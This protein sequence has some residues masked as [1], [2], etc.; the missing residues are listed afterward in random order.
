METES[1]IEGQGTFWEVDNIAFRGI[2]KNFIG[3]KIKAEFL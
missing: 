3:E 1:E 2:N